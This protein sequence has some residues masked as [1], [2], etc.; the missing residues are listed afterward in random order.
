MIL[1]IGKVTKCSNIHVQYNMG[2]NDTGPASTNIKILILTSCLL[3]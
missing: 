1:L 2:A 3:T